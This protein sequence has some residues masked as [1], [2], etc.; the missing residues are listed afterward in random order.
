MTKVEEYI[1]ELPNSLKEIAKHL[2]SIIL[3]SHPAI[4]ES[5]KYK[6]PFY[7]YKKNLCYFYQKG[8]NLILG[9]VQGY[10]LAQNNPV[11]V[12]DQKQVRHIIINKI[13]DDLESEIRYVLQE[14]IL[15]N[16]ELFKHNKK[17]WK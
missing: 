5:F 3:Q 13:K 15:L 6:C 10:K 9:F 17:Q 8:D 7:D 12:G 14:A 16:D 11:L 4:K 1:L 2:R